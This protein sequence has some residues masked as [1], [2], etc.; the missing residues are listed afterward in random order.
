MITER[1][2]LVMLEGEIPKSENDPHYT[3]HYYQSIQVFAQATLALCEQ[4]NFKK[5]NR[6][7]RVVLKLFN[8]GNDTV[9]NGIVN[10]YLHTVS[11]FLDTHRAHKKWM[12]AYMPAELQKEYARQHYTSGI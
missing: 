3:M 2:A 4:N 10:V 7:L 12:E 6:H 11:H 9:R 5:L 8:G 1:T